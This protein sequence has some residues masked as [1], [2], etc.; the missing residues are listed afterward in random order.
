MSSKAI[1][2]AQLTLRGKSVQEVEQIKSRAEQTCSTT[3]E[4]GVQFFDPDA[5]S[6]ALYHAATNQMALLFAVSSFHTP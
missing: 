4:D 5:D 3:D 1:H 6:V 2:E